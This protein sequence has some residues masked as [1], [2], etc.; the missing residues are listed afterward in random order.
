MNPCPLHSDRYTVVTGAPCSG[1]TTYILEH[2]AVGD[3]MIDFDRL[4]QAVSPQSP[5]HRYPEHIREVVRV[6]RLAAIRHILDAQS[7]VRL[8]VIDT[9]IRDH[10][11]AVARYRRLGATVIELDPGLDVCIERAKAERPPEIVSLVSEWYEQR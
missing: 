7:G 10:A 6:M 3:V 8:W 5:K 9:A 1:K 11:A 2:M 4:A